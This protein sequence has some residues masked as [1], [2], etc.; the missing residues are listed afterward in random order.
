[1]K[2]G[3]HTAVNSNRV[4][5]VIHYHKR[6]LLFEAEGNDEDVECRRDCCRDVRRAVKRLAV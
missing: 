4:R 6:S 5:F 3:I 1:M 2:V